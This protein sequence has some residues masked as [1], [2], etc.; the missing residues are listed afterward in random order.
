MTK[1]KI[2]SLNVSHPMI[3]SFKI[4]VEPV[5]VPVGDPYGLFTKETL[6]KISDI[7]NKVEWKT[8]TYAERNFLMIYNKRLK[9]HQLNSN[10]NGHK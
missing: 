3:G 8:E 4:E 9:K 6:R 5:T 7:K 10:K 1:K 2:V